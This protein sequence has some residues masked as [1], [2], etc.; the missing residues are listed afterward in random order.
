ME[1]PKDNESTDHNEQL[2]NLN[3]KGD[4]KRITVLTLLYRHPK[5][6]QKTVCLHE[7]I[8]GRLT[9][10]GHCDSEELKITIREIYNDVLFEQI[11]RQCEVELYSQLN[12]QQEKKFQQNTPKIVVSKTIP[13]IG[14]DI[15]SIAPRAIVANGR[16]AFLYEHSE[17]PHVYVRV[18]EPASPSDNEVGAP[19]GEPLTMTLEQDSNQIPLW[20]TMVSGHLQLHYPTHS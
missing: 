17:N 14:E 10:T 7:L 16:K 6:T 2:R 19:N 12:S 13:K 5:S 15:K 11:E 20:R 18:Y 1:S 4:A 3:N 9:N 8:A